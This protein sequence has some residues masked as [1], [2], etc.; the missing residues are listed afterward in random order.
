MTRSSSKRGDQPLQSQSRITRAHPK[1]HPSDPEQKT[2]PK[3]SDLKIG[4]VVNWNLSSDNINTCVSSEHWPLDV[5]D[6]EQWPVDIVHLLH[7]ASD[8]TKGK[9][10]LFK[11]M[12]KEEIVARQKKNKSAKGKTDCMLSTDLKKVCKRLKGLAQETEDTGK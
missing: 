2:S 4:I 5:P 8:Y 6:P 11:Q 1:E 7:Q 3:P 9:N 12:L 10:D